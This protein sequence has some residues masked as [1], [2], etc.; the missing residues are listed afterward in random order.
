[1]RIASLVARTS[2]TTTTFR[3]NYYNIHSATRRTILC[4]SAR[5]ASL[6]SPLSFRPASSS[7]RLARSLR[8]FHLPSSSSSSTRP[9]TFPQYRNR[10][11]AFAF[12]C[13]SSVAFVFHLATSSD[14]RIQLEFK[15]ADSDPE[16]DKQEHQQE[17]IA[18]N[19]LWKPVGV[20]G[21]AR[22]LWRALSLTALFAPL[23]LALPLWL[24]LGPG[25]KLLY[26]PI[27]EGLN[28]DNDWFLLLATQTLEF[29]G[30]IPIKLAQWASMR[31]DVFHPAVCRVLA[32]LQSSVSPHP[33][34]HTI[35]A[36]E[37]ALNVPITVT[38]RTV[39]G[40]EFLRPDNPSHR[41][42]LLRDAF[43]SFEPTPI[44]VGAV[45]QVHR[46]TLRPE[47]GGTIVAVKILHPNA[48]SL[49][50]MDLRLLQTCGGLLCALFPTTAHTLAV[51]D[52]LA[53][54]A[55]MMRAQL[56]L[57]VEY[58]NLAQF[59]RNWAP[60]KGQRALP[61]TFPQGLMASREVLVEEFVLGLPFRDIVELGHTA[62]D[63]ELV[64][65][66]LP[67]FIRM[68]LNHNFVHADLHAGNI[69]FHLENRTDP[70]IIPTPTP[71]PATLY[72]R[73]HN[74]T[75]SQRRA[76]LQDLKNA[77]YTPRLTFL[78]VGLTARLR[79]R[80]ALNLHLV[81]EAALDGRG[82]DLA[83]VLMARCRDP[84]RVRDPAAAREEMRALVADLGLQE[85]GGGAAGTLPL[86]LLKSREVVRRAADFFRKYRIGMDGEWV[87]L[88]VAGVLVE[89]I[90]RELGG[91]IDVLEV[92]MDEM[93]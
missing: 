7:L 63:D 53:T 93:P 38:D 80:N 75:P 71:L 65:I 72:H 15:Q 28:L 35:V 85:G 64:Q 52:E 24:L 8:S 2:T 31:Q 91:D 29:A 67:A 88:F 11:A 6:H 82:G 32:R 5:V 33:C 87:G 79:A 13:A 66:G 76:L 22:L 61:V 48:T 69:L 12:G 1:M 59:R 58:A 62:F 55:C 39:I 68:V 46:A 45:A 44:G 77:G 74:A 30:P 90:A 86:S 92:L 3:N 60:R 9:P 17:F 26:D 36:I 57:R 20:A 4:V 49:V 42:I 18:D 51:A 16:T 21:H 19:P 41:R 50:E 56:D 54:F 10:F 43:S 40:G 34:S 83:D 73:L 14:H 27:P 70:T 23:L 47:L 37:D 25:R 78:D 81:L 89:G 84:A